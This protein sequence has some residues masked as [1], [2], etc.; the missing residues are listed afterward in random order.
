MASTV[1]GRTNA[2]SAILSRLP[3]TEYQA[4][5][6]HLQRVSLVAGQHVIEAGQ[7]ID[8][9]LLPAGAV[10][11]KLDGRSGIATAFLGRDH[12]VGVEALLTPGALAY[13]GVE[14]IA[15]GVAY[16]LRWSDW[17]ALA[18]SV[19]TLSRLLLSSVA[20]QWAAASQQ[21]ACA[22]RC[23]VADRVADLLLTLQGQVATC[24]IPITQEGISRLLGVGR[25]TVNMALSLLDGQ[26]MTRTWRGHI[27]VTD[28]RVS[29]LGCGCRDKVRAYGAA[30]ACSVPGTSP[31]RCDAVADQ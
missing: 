9:L 14:V 2:C 6:P 5:M 15:P 19:P 4:L 20:V 28:R 24:S 18:P 22:T 10:C 11:A 7:R 25:T 16:Q 23:G 27:T 29:G 12:A 1:D 8:V 31:Q 3:V 17:A 26:G 30:L 21:V 13:A